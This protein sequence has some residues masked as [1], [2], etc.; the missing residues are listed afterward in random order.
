MSQVL[1]Y[2]FQKKHLQV[3][4]SWTITQGLAEARKTF[5]KPLTNQNFNFR[6]ALVLQCNPQ[7][8]QDVLE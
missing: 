4:S 5:Q 8:Y 2:L 1:Q 6:I 3:F 7:I